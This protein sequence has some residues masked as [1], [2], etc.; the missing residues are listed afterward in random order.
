LARKVRVLTGQN[1]DSAAMRGTREQS[2]ERACGQRRVRVAA[3]I[4]ALAA[5]ASTARAAEEKKPTEYEIKAACIYNLLKYTEWPPSPSPPSTDTTDK[6][7][8]AEPLHVGVVG[9]DPFGKAWDLIRGKQVGQRTIAVTHIPEFTEGV[10]ATPGFRGCN[11]L[12]I[13]T[14]EEPKLAAILG[15]VKDVPVLTLGEM[16]AFLERGGMI[17]F[18][19][20]DRKVRFEINLRAV[21]AARLGINTAVLRL[22]RRIIQAEEGSRDSGSA[23]PPDHSG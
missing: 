13:C 7:P 14:S 18:A 16:N 5:F 11:V 23:A 12:F 19:L 15:A 6:A 1:V 3:S 10:A 17:A 21:R 8:P 4:L 2:F 9:A 20:E 22:A